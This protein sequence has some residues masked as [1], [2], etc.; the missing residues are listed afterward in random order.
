MLVYSCEW[1]KRLKRPGERW[2][3]GFAAERFDSSG[4]QRELTIVSSWSERWAN[5]RLAVHFCCPEHKDDYARHLFNFAE[6]RPRRGG[7]AR[8]AAPGKLPQTSDS[9]RN[10]PSVSAAAPVTKRERGRTSLMRRSEKP[11]GTQRLRERRGTRSAIDF[12]KADRLR[13]HGMGIRLEDGAA[14]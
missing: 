4:W 14:E 13:A 2:I 5:H 8:R 11:A 9:P 3:L 12:S 7:R 6:V 10:A 1:C